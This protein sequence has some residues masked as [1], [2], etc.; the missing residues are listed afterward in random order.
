M[1]IFCENEVKVRKIYSVVFEKN[2]I[3]TF[4]CMRATL[5]NDVIEKIKFWV[6]DIC[7]KAPHAEFQPDRTSSYTLKICKPISQ[8]VGPIVNKYTYI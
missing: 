4:F 2:A 1:V 3:F 7:K 5:K 8:E 6:R